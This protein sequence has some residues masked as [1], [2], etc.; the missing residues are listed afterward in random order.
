L[1]LR[2]RRLGSGRPGERRDVHLP[3]ERSEK[4]A[5]V[6]EMTDKLGAANAVV[7]ADYRGLNVAQLA[8]LR[9]ELRQ[10]GTELQVIKNS[11]ARRALENAGLE[12]LDD[13]L[14]GPTLVALLGEDLSSPLKSMAKVNKDTEHLAIKGG[15]LGGKRIDARA[16]AALADLP[17]REELLS[18]FLGLLEA[19]QRQLLAVLEAPQR[20]LVSVLDAHAKAA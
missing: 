17:S 15:L 5:I 16:V 2:A 1:L 9:R 10:F 8:A 11:L 20:E 14:V 19:P 3:L 4:E 18:Q 6:A 12:S 7:V 13:V